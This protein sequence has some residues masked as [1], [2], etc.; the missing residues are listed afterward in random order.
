MAERLRAIWRAVL[1]CD[2]PHD[3]ANFFDLGGHSLLAIELASQA[4]QAF[5]VRL[6]VIDVFDRPVFADFAAHIART[7][8]D[9]PASA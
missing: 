2:V 8:G 9:A 6:D 7:I 1:G 3:T 4:E 5:G